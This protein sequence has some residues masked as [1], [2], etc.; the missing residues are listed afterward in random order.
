MH[1]N[2]GLLFK[3]IFVIGLVTVFLDIITVLRNSHGEVKSNLI[4]KF[5]KVSNNIDI[6]GERDL[7]LPKMQI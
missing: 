2:I 6:T 3:H 7:K 5:H 1:V 4:F